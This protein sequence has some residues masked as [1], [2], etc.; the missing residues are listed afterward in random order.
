MSSPTAAAT[1][2]DFVPARPA[3]RIASAARAGCHQRRDVAVAANASRAKNNAAVN[4]C[5]IAIEVLSRSTRTPPSSPCEMTPIKTSA[6]TTFIQR[7]RSSTIA[8]PKNARQ[9]SPMSMPPSR[10]VCSRNTCQRDCGAPSGGCAVM[11]YVTMFCPNVV[12]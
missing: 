12:G 11:S 9:H 4:P 8:A 3:G 5:T 6:A 10:C 7:R 2:I 1:A